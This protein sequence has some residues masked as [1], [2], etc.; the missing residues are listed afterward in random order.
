MSKKR[1]KIINTKNEI[2]SARI[3]LDI[4]ET[5]NQHSCKHP[6]ASK[7]AGCD[8]DNYDP[9]DNSYWW[10]FECP[11]CRKRWREPQ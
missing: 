1:E 8:R 4:R 9:N 3:I 2:Q 5:K 11:D 7:T 6:Y 10:D